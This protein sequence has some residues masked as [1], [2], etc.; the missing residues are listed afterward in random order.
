MPLPPCHSR[1]EFPDG[2]TLYFCAH[3]Q[4]H[5][6]D[7]LVT[8]E[9]CQ[10]CTYCHL[11]P[12]TEFRHFDPAG[13]I[14]RAGP[15][16]FIGEQTGWK[17][18]TTCRGNVQLKVFACQHLLHDET[19]Y[20][21]CAKCRDYENPLETGLVRQWAVGM[22]TAPRDNPTLQRTLES[23]AVAGW[24]DVR[25]FAEPETEIPAAFSA[26]PISR[27]DVRLGAFPNWYLALGELVMRHPLVDAYL[28]CQDDVVFARGLRTY[29]E[30]H[31]WPSPRLGVVSVYSACTQSTQGP[32]GFHVDKRGRDVGGALALIFPNPAARAFLGHPYVLNHRRRGPEQGLHHID[33]VVGEWCRRTRLPFY[34][35]APSL[36]QHI[37]DTST[38]FPGAANSG[39]RRARAFLADIPP[40][41]AN[42]ATSVVPPTTQ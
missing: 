20:D 35:H 23:L 31:L 21:E 29:L 16:F 37:G 42:E 36:A 34:L 26:L 5:A 6:T 14:R 13:P 38:I 18:C 11:P 24:G 25:L 27:R 40:P 22:T 4:V 10:V 41:C 19:T 32:M 12:P 30:G 7:Q 2:G 28:L 39:H 15:C 8:A 1:R 17:Q 33:A 9:V 3:P